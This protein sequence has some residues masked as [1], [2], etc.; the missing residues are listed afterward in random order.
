MNT[1]PEPRACPQCGA[2][3]PV[4][5]A[6]GLCPRC[7]LALNFATQSQMAGDTQPPPAGGPVVPPLSLEAVAGLFPQ[8]EIIR[9]VGLGGMGAVYQARQPA[10]DRHVALKLLHTPPA[11]DP[12]F[13]ERFSQEARA[14]AKL[15][16]PNIVALHEFGQAGGRP[17]FL[18][19]FVD[20]VNLRQLQQ[21]GRL[22]PREALQIVPQVC[23]ALQYAHDEG[24]V[25]RDIKP[26][27]VLIDRKGRVKVADFGLAK[28]MGVETAATRLTGAGHVMGTPH[29]MAPEQVEHPLDVD[30]R[31]DIF[32]LGVVFYELLTGELPLGKFP[33]PSKK[34]RIDVRLD[35]VVLRA[36]EKEPALRYAQASE[37]K[38]RVETIAG[39]NPSCGVSPEEAQEGKFKTPP[40]DEAGDDPDLIAQWCGKWGWKLVSFLVIILAVTDANDTFWNV[41][42]GAWLVLFMAKE[43]FGIR[44]TQ[45][46]GWVLAPDKPNAK[47]GRAQATDSAVNGGKTPPRWKRVKTILWAVLVIGAV[48]FGIRAFVL[49]PYRV[50]TS[51]VSPEIPRGSLVFV[52]KPVRHFS[53]GDIIAYHFSADEIRVGRVAQEDAGIVRIERRGETPQPVM[54]ADIIGRVVFN[55]RADP[56]AESRQAT[57]KDISEAGA[58]GIQPRPE[59]DVLVFGPEVKLEVKLTGEPGGYNLAT[60]K[61]VAFTPVKG[62]SMPTNS[63][64]WMQRFGVDVIADPDAQLPAIFF[65]GALA[66]EVSGAAWDESAAAVNASAPK[67]LHTDTFDHRL[68]VLALSAWDAPKTYRIRTQH[69]V[70]GVLQLIGVSENSRGVKIR[71]KLAQ[72]ASR[73]EGAATPLHIEF[74]RNGDTMQGLV[75]R[76][77]RDYGVRLCFENLDFDAK[78]D[79][80]TLGQ[81]LRQLSER[82]RQG[83]ITAKEKERLTVARRLKTDEKL[84]EDTLLDVGE[85]Y[86]GRVAAETVEDFLDQLTRG[87]PYGWRKSGATWVIVP[88]GGSRLLFPVTLRTSGLN[89]EEAVA[90]I[91]EQR[92]VGSE[93]HAGMVVAMPVPTAPG[94]DAMPWLRSRLP[95]LDLA[96]V[97]ALDALCR[98]TEAA[99][100][101]ALWELAGYKESR[102]LGL[103]AGPNKAREKPDAAVR[104]DN[105]PVFGPV[106]ECVVNGAVDLETGRIASIDANTGRIAALPESIERMDDFAGTI[107]ETVLWMV[108]E[109]LDVFADS[110]EFAGLDLLVVEQTSD[111]WDRLSAAQV[112]SLLDAVTTKA[113]HYAKLKA[114]ENTTY[115]FQTRE[116]MRGVLQILGKANDKGVKLRYKRLQASSEAAGAPGAAQAWLALIDGGHYAESWDAAATSFH[117]AVTRAEWTS[118][119][120]KIRGPLGDV[121]SRAFAKTQQAKTFPGMPDGAYWIAEFDT[122]FA[123]LKSAAEVVVLALEKDGQWRAISYLIRPR[124]EM[125]Q[126]A[127][128][129]ARAWLASIDED[130]YA[131]SWDHASALFRGAPL[132]R[133]KWVSALERVRRP[134]G[135]LVFRTVNATRLASTLPGAPAGQYVVMQFDASFAGDK[136]AVETVTFM[137]E[138]DGQWRAAGYFI[139]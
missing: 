136:S 4:G 45:R 18:M 104:P 84:S 75:S 12:G 127:V 29:Y 87:T 24:I 70:A 94:A 67:L 138:K 3:I 115:V 81:T 103:V 58:N 98:V 66:E 1:P 92:P 56:F 41:L 10:L 125:E 90:K 23:D 105:A 69:G 14:L 95:A 44:Y 9:L 6:E 135:G 31:A 51:A 111:Q 99:R 123:G 39:E 20:G 137:Q 32:S 122:K 85:H 118:E 2:P 65:V 93:I 133:E 110:P 17:Y 62:E 112:V 101:D 37:L 42:M 35:E 80:V 27:N 139:K 38:T 119:A 130:H 109:G 96:A 25:H 71:Y 132:T 113:P 8:L 7:L 124:T 16:H 74:D 91:L 60:G 59:T 78:K 88:R 34:V 54:A 72:P 83:T 28:L 129:A 43:L 53:V 48:S 89:L 57:T 117:E 50:P 19:E 116:G 63:P 106:I 114:A 120:A 68:M 73:G 61:F 100:P 86:E 102:M 49:A 107:F 40:S 77:Q 55:T 82:E 108:Q 26:E 128:V 46:R 131:E 5:A 13:A 121:I 97:S 36:L 76:V 79:A 33:L 126:A 15:N 52:F 11:N 22:S 64:A 134:L 21:A 47:Q 30:H